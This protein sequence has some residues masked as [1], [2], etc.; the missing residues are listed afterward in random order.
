MDVEL[1]EALADS[2]RKEVL[3]I[4]VSNQ[5]PTRAINL[6]RAHQSRLLPLPPRLNVAVIHGTHTKMQ[7]SLVLYICLISH[8]SFET[9]LYSADASNLP[10]IDDF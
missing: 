2:K 9:Y 10:Q 8:A 4:H 3:V 1:R 6:V 7:S 5:L